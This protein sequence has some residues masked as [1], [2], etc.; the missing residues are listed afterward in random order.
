[1]VICKIPRSL[2][3]SNELREDYCHDPSLMNHRQDFEPDRG[4]PLQAPL[5]QRED[6]CQ[7]Q[8]WEDMV[9]QSTHDFEDVKVVNDEA[10]SKVP[11]GEMGI[12]AANPCFTEKAA[13]VVQAPSSSDEND[14]QE[15]DWEDMIT[16]PTHELEDVKADNDKAKSKV[17]EGEMGVFLSVPTRS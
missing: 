16:Q 13:Q 14:R 9:P 3:A 8:D 1:M 15:Q 2:Q 12:C 10:E 5:P 4:Q 11:K 17:P 6:D 7:E